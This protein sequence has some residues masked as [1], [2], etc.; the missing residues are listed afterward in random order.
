VASRLTSSI[1]ARL[2]GGAVAALQIMTPVNALFVI[3]RI[4]VVRTAMAIMQ[5]GIQHAT[6]GTRSFST[7]FLAIIER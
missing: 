1:S 5:P 7:I 2:I 6:I 4:T 3:E